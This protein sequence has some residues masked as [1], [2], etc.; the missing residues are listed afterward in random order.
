WHKLCSKNGKKE[1][2]RGE[3]EADIRFVRNNMTASMFDLSMKDNSRSTLGRLKDK[4]KGKK[5]GGFS[6]SASAIVPSIGTPGDSDDDDAVAPVTEKKK[7]SKLKRLFPKSNLQRT[8]LSQSMSVIPTAPSTSPGNPSK[9][10]DFG[11]EDFTEIKLHDS[12]E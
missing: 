2:E 4:L 10:K 12:A 5:K 8:S 9:A 7:K 3:I 1:K 11:K 6:D